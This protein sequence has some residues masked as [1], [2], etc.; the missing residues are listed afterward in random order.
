[1]RLPRVI[2]ERVQRRTNEQDMAGA[3]PRTRLLFALALATLITHHWFASTPLPLGGPNVVL[4]VLATLA[5]ALHVA[6]H[7]RAQWPTLIASLRPAAAAIAVALL[8]LVWALAVHGLTSTAAP[9]RLAQT[10]LGLGVLCATCLAVQ[11]QRQAI[12]M[13]IVFVVATFVSALFGLAVAFLQ[14]PFLS[15]W[16]LIADVQPKFLEA[17]W[18]SDRLA[19]IAADTPAFGYQLVVALPFALAALLFT[20]VHRG[21]APL[22]W[23]GGA[24]YIMLMTFITALAIDGSRSVLVAATISSAFVVVLSLRSAAAAWRAGSAVALM[25]L[26]FIVIFSPALHSPS[27]PKELPVLADAVDVRVPPIEGLAVGI[28]AQPAASARSRVAT[29]VRKLEP[30]ATYT[31]QLRARHLKTAGRPGEIV[32]TASPAGRITTSWQVPR[33]LNFIRYESR[34]RRMGEADWSKWHR[35]GPIGDN[36]LSQQ[37][38]ATEMR[39]AEWR[40]RWAPNARLLN[41][42]AYSTNSRVLMAREAGRLALSE[43][44]GA[45]RYALPGTALSE[46]LPGSPQGIELLRGDPHNQFLLALVD[47]GLPGVALLMLFYL[48]AL[49]SL[50]RAAQ[51][52][53]RSGDTHTLNLV[54]AVCGAMV[55][56]IVYSL[57][58]SRGPFT[59]DW[60]HF[61]LIGLAF[62]L[63]RIAGARSAQRS[64]APIPAQSASEGAGSA[65]RRSSQ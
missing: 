25:A 48:I 19:G 5:A 18:A 65:E 14:E 23:L 52:A 1:M 53:R 55:A 26:G 29:E 43:P 32:A 39:H 28:G 24:S 21:H 16:L 60:A 13:A 20:P 59:G 9:L 40:R 12:L 56:Y 46:I 33:D 51:I 49:R 63:Q 27:E 44:L 17:L 45:G 64:P 10:A 42:D 58:H 41:W 11:T 37:A 31:V 3:P 2:A 61:I 50:V 54:V 15:V 36:G 7:G 34:V 38:I 8:A 4:G 6:R 57:A 62:S 47:Y 35:Q 30:G 22:I